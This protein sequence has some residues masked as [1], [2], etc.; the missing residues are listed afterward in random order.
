VAAWLHNFN[1]LADM[2]IGIQFPAVRVTLEVCFAIEYLH[3][4]SIYIADAASEVYGHKV[5]LITAV[6][7]S[8]NG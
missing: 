1:L 7:S 3:D 6:F 4:L 8:Y 5:Q 2:I